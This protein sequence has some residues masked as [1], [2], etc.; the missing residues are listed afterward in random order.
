MVVQEIILPRKITFFAQR[1]GHITVAILEM[2]SGISGGTLRSQR[3]DECR[4]AC[5]IA[6]RKGSHLKKLWD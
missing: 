2:K 1:K 6:S 3:A 4:R 5:G